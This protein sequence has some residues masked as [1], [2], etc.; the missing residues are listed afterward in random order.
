[1]RR[2]I[3]AALVLIVGL[4]RYV[5]ATESA[6]PAARADDLVRRALDRRR[7][8]D[9]AGAVDLLRQAEELAPS[10]RILAQLGF[11]EF[12]LQHWV[13]AE[14]DLERALAS[15]ES[16]WLAIPKNR[17]MLEKTLAETRRHVAQIEI[18]GTPGAQ[19]SLDGRSAG[20]LPLAS[21]IRVT[22][23]TV[24][25]TAT[26][27]GRHAFEQVLTLSGGE[28]A[29]IRVDLEP[30]APVAQPLVGARD[31]L[32][33]QSDQT[34]V[35]AWRRW[36]GAGLF[37]VGVAAIGTGVVW[38]ALDGRPNCTPPAG[39]FCEQVYD[40]KT[41]GWISIAAGAVAAGAG[42]TLY[43]WK[44]KTETTAVAVG[45]GILSLRGRF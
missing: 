13:A 39:G 28:R 15:P 4:G 7:Q 24:R 40:T 36:T 38:V 29:S 21:P 14:E 35:P 37:A 18:A 44:R 45:P 34:S 26:A 32:A 11:A 16:S 23:G 41:Q 3:V 27:A 25:L 22:A 2:N 33:E 10:G 31:M 43:L 20:V 5:G 8:G 42:A 12:A 9:N 6:S 19:V 30:V 1:M 17:E